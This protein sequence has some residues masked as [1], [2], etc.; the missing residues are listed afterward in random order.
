MDVFTMAGGRFTPEQVNEIIDEYVSGGSITQMA[1]KYRRFIKCSF[2]KHSA[3][4]STSA[5]KSKRLNS[6]RYLSLYIC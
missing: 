4:T 1:A 6:F 2:N 3:I 5:F